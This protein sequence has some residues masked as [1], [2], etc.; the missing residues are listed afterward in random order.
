[1]HNFEIDRL[2]NDKSLDHITVNIMQLRR[3][4]AGLAEDTRL[5]PLDMAALARWRGTAMTIN[6]LYI[7]ASASVLTWSHARNQSKGAQLF[8]CW[9]VRVEMSTVC[10]EWAFLAKEVHVTHLDL[11]DTVDLGLVIILAWRINTLAGAV[12]R[13]QFLPIGGLIVW[14]HRRK[15]SGS[16]CFG[17]PSAHDYRCS[18]FERREAIRGQR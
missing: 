2:A 12:A 16:C 15:R 8:L 9:L 18:W 17:G 5:S 1:M 10:V 6:A 14:R 13:N 7:L 4:F 3:E 11:L